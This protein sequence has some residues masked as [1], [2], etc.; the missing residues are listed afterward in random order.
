MNIVDVSKSLWA[1]RHF[2]HNSK[3]IVWRGWDKLHYSSI[4]KVCSCNLGGIV[5]MI[6]GMGWVEGGMKGDG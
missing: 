4:S 5:A 1:E 6:K 3:E 2:F